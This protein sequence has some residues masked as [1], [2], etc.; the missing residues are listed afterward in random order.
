M[1]ALFE[2]REALFWPV[3]DP[4]MRHSARRS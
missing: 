1:E 2:P 3:L 4:A